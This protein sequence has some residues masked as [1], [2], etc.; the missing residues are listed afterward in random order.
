MSTKLTKFITKTD[1]K[2]RGWTESIIKKLNLQP[3]LLK[4]NPHYKKAPL[5]KL[6]SI[7]SVEKLEQSNK[8]IELLK[9]SEK[10]KKS[11]KK[12]V[13]TKINKIIDYIK[14]LTIIIP[15]K[16]IEELRNDAIEHYN[17]LRIYE[18]I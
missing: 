17:N 16:S 13:E 7:E 5:M 10:R 11:A 12:A 4:Q 2:K 6:Y 18:K 3:D 9:N 8:F 1:L 14:S 15:K